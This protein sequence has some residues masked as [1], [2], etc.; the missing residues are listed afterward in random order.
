MTRR[1]ANPEARRIAR[2]RIA[3]LFARAKEAFSTNPALADRYVSLARKIS[4]KQRVRL[5]REFRRQFC[6]H[7]QRFLVP[8]VNARVRISRGKVVVTCLSCKRQ[9]RY[10]IRRRT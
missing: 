9:T 2:E 8:G 5:D 4:M 7:C 3:I 1:T 6:H 10:P